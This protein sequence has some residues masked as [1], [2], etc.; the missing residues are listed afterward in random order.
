[1]R[2]LPGISKSVLNLFVQNGEY[3]STSGGTWNTSV[4]TSGGG[5]SFSWGSSFLGRCIQRTL[6]NSSIKTRCTHGAILCVTGDLL[7][8]NCLFHK[9]STREIKIILTEN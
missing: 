7:K 2:D 5:S 6:G 1:M 9:D 3:F 8:I 4:N